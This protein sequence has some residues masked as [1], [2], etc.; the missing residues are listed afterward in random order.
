MKD[1]N[2]LNTTLFE[3]LQQVKDKQLDARAA[4][5]IVS[6]SNAIISSGKLQ[7][8]AYKALGG[9]TAPAMLGISAN[10][11]ARPTVAAAKPKP[12]LKDHHLISSIQSVKPSASAHR[13]EE[14]FAKILGYANRSTAEDALGPSAF[15][16]KYT[17]WKANQ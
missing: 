8:Q 16:R 15:K 6:I 12:P 11:T 10:E 3:T 13:D 7:L 5:T 4:N 1:L 9:N 14:S 2:D 17:T